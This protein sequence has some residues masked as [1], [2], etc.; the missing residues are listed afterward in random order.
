MKRRQSHPSPFDRQHRAS[1]DFVQL[2]Q[3]E[4]WR[5]S[6]VS[7]Q[8]CIPPGSYYT[9]H[10]PYVEAG[11]LIISLSLFRS[12]LSETALKAKPCLLANVLMG[13]RL[14][15]TVGSQPVQQFP[16]VDPSWH[17]MVLPL[18]KRLLRTF[19]VGFCAS[20]MANG[21]RTHGMWPTG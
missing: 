16:A 9:I 2:M 5:G 7:K 8:D 13:T 17:R 1:N 10:L 4:K 12:S 20:G 3:Q 18:H 19:S 15:I 6:G 21:P 14:C 11:R